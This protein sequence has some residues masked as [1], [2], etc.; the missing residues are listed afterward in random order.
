VDIDDI[1][2][3]ALIGSEAANTVTDVGG[4]A[5]SNS[6]VIRAC[7]NFAAVGYKH[8]GYNIGGIAGSQMG[9]I[10]HC[11]NHGSISGRKEVGG[12]SGQVEPIS[13]MEFSMD[14]LQILQGQLETMQELT[15]RASSNAQGGMAG[16]SGELGVLGSHTAN[17][18]DAIG[19]LIPSE[20]QKGEELPEK[21]YANAIAQEVI[22]AS[23]GNVFTEVTV[24]LD[25]AP[26]F[27]LTAKADYVGTVT[28][29]Y[30]GNE[31]TYE[32][33]EGNNKIVVDVMKAYNFGTTVTI[34]AEG[35]SGTYNLDTYAKYI[36]ENGT[37]ADKAIVDAFY[38]YVTVA[39][40]YKASIEA[41]AA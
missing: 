24:S 41:P 14:T 12:I 4:I 34:T 38:N 26:K 18:M 15:D 27:V 17:A 21:T 8:M 39:A 33:T 28:V 25:S 32:I 11:E 7:V 2:V 1:S 35:A 22:D 36:A 29:S 16:V 40:Q 31:Y 13:Q 3:E 9:Y 23:F 30:G 37:D 5:G 20:D 6:G 19:T 10:T